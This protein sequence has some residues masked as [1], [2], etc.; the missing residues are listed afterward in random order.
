MLP[1]SYTGEG[2]PIRLF[3]VRLTR[4]TLQIDYSNVL[5]WTGF[6]KKV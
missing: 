5:S 1:L 3:I 6:K 4:W 2:R